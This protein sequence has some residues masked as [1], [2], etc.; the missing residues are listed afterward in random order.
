VL[1][2]ILDA[3]EIPVDGSLQ[4]QIE[5]RSLLRLAQTGDGGPSLFDHIIIEKEVK[6]SNKLRIGIRTERW[7]F[8]FD[9]VEQT[10]ELYDLAED[11]TEQQNV[12][13]NHREVAAEFEYVLQ[14]R[15]SQIAE[16]SANIKIP[17]ISES[18]EVEERLRALGYIE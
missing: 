12:I 13:E 8:I 6:G 17:E 10:Q 18:E 11:P 9:G 1:P 7:K 15:F 3:N 5:G 14:R 4:R 16:R 2:T